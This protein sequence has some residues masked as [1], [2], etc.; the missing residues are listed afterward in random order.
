MSTLNMLLMQLGEPA[1]VEYK[2]VTLMD[3]LCYYSVLLK[4]G[5]MKYIL[6]ILWGLALNECD[7]QFEISF[8]Q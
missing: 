4:G 5:E 3:Q 7:R 6:Y 2:L 1:S 8:I